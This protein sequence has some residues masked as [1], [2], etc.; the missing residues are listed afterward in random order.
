MCRVNNCYFLFCNMLKIKSRELSSKFAVDSSSNKIS[1]SLINALIN[2]IFA[3]VQ[4]KDFYYQQ[5]IKIITTFFF[6]CIKKF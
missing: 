3:F 4:M 2:A 1:T 5:S 6:E